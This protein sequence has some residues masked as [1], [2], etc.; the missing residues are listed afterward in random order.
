MQHVVDAVDKVRKQEHKALMQKGDATLVRSKYLWLTNPENMTDRARV[1]FAELKGIELKTG[2]AWA[3][4]ESLRTLWNHTSVTEATKFWKRWYFWAT[5]SRL[6][7]M[8]AA[9][10]LVARHVRNVLTYFT[11][12]L[13][14]AVAEGLN[15]KIAT[16]QKRACGFRNPNHFKIAIFFHCGGLN[17]YPTTRYTLTHSNV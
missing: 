9:A 14:N 11:H 3:L 8:I 16:L 13:T 7:P 1:R 12:H 15:S 10:K 17:L 4:K 2:R 5:H 6:P